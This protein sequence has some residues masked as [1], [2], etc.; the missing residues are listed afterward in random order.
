VELNNERKHSKS[1]I[2]TIRGE[3]DNS[4]VLSYVRTIL[5]ST[6]NSLNLGLN[7]YLEIYFQILSVPSEKEIT[8]YSRKGHIYFLNKSYFGNRY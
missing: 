7:I 3:Q 6:T 2:L 4:R 8:I 1:N 5:Q